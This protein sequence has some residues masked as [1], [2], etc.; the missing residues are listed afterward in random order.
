MGESHLMW[1]HF[2]RDNH[3]KIES[4][5]HDLK[6]I[7]NKTA[8]AEKEIRAKRKKKNRR[9]RNKPRLERPG[10]HNPGC[11][12][13]VTSSPRPCDPGD[14]AWVGSRNL[15]LSL[16]DLTLSLSLIW[17]PSLWSDSLF[18]IWSDRWGEAVLETWEM[19][20]IF[21]NYKSS[22]KDSIFKFL[23]HGK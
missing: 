3:L 7:Y 5:R 20:K 16:S 21:L 10:S 19:F 12:T 8:L 2:P 4:Q 15:F 14:A 13:W 17:S 1:H 22:L 23:P 9:R 18:L 11:A 6:P